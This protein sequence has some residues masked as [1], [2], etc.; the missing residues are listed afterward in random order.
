M[1]DYRDYDLLDELDCADSCE[2]VSALCVLIDQLLQDIRHL[3]LECINTRYLLSQHMDNEQG[4]L[5]RMDILETLGRR[6]GND[7]AYVLYKNL[8]YDGGY[9][10]EF[11]DYLAKVREA[12]KGNWLCWH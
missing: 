4:E 11:R 10:M 3:E 1:A 5:L 9:P 12:C 6:Y 8:M 2:A 7:P